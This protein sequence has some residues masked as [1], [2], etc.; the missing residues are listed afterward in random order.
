MNEFAF[1][2][3]GEER[4]LEATDGE[5]AI[6]EVILDIVKAGGFPTEPIRFVRK[7]KDYVSAVIGPSDIARFKWTDRS[8]WI[9]LPYGPDGKTKHA[10]TDPEEVRNYENTVLGHYFIAF[11]NALLGY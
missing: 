7:S 5:K 6:F 1:A 8:K 3:Y 10:L 4:P 2:H 11:G 9:Q